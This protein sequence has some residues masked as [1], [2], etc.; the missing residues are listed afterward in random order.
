M[1]LPRPLFLAFSIFFVA[2]CQTASRWGATDDSEWSGRIG[3]ARYADVVGALGQPRATLAGVGG[4]TKAR[5][6]GDTLTVNPA[7][8]SIHDHSVQRTEERPIWRDM[9][10]SSDGILLRA[11]TSDQRTLADS[12]PP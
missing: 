7:P 2:G 12:Q 9:L 3:T 4:E 5:W 11:W 10:F 6:A 8:G 1:P